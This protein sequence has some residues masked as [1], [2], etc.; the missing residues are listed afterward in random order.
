MRGVRVSGSVR[1]AHAVLLIVEER[2]ELLPMGSCRRVGL[3]ATNDEAERAN[4][5]EPVCD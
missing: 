4:A 5:E 2:V 3:R 1:A